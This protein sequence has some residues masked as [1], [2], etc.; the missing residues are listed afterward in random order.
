MYVCPKKQRRLKAVAWNSWRAGGLRLGLPSARR[1][2]GRLLEALSTIR[3]R[4][5]FRRWESCFHLLIENLAGRG[6]LV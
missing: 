3:V 2:A 5:A 6:G 1:V 4:R